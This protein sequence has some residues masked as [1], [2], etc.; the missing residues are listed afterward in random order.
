MS[1]SR[2][3]YLGPRLRRLRR[4]LG[5][6]QQG[7][8]ED[9]AISA[10]YIAL[11]ERNQR[12]V[13]AEL[14]LRLAKSYQLEIADLAS[15]D[16]D[17]YARRIAEVMRDPLLEG[18]DLPALEIADLATSFPGVA[19]AILRLH[20][21]YAREQ[22][23]LADR[24]LG[25]AASE[26]GTPDP[27]RAVQEF[28][29]ANRNHFPTLDVRAEELAAEI[30]EHGAAAEWLRK[31]KGVRVRFMPPEVMVE[32]VRRYDRHNDQVLIDDSLDTSARKFQLAL[33]IAWTT[34][35][36]E[37]VQLARAADLPDKSAVALAR[38]NLAAYAA[39]AL[40]MPYD[41]FIKAAES[42]GYDVAA[43]GGVFG[44]SFEQ[45]AHRLTT[46]ARPGHEGVPFFMVRLD[47]AGNVSK[48]LDGAGFPYA[49]HGG[50]CP[51]WRVH[52][53]FRTPG[54]IVTQWLELP[55]T[56][57]FFTIART[58]GGEPRHFGAPAAVRSVALVC[59]AEHAGRLAYAR[60]ADPATAEATPIGV[61]CRLCQRAD[62]EARAVPPIGR[63]LLAD[64]QRRGIAPFMFADR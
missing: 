63:E 5:L 24:R 7:M 25:A 62:C 64:D 8:A 26:P 33:H 55:D 51:L 37:I 30:A 41:R 36:D 18:I 49:P 21:A 43:L 27:V 38:R 10:S 57:R 12:P 40:V 17:D 56:R 60:G 16:A 42:R 32:S 31:R 2:P 54:Q 19:E 44:M 34:M 15:E 61:N 3:L 35:R 14:L 46:L 45:V 52:D 58:V 20:G 23:V 59:A 6:T 11:L 47:A 48:L 13:T 39:A 1:Q 28:F 29:S 22:Q 53:T 4:E 9:L 50:S